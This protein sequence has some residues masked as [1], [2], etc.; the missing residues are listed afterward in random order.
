MLPKL[1][2]PNLSDR[3][4]SASFD[5]DNADPAIAWDTFK[6]FSQEPVDGVSEGFLWEIGCFN[7][8]GES[9]FIINLVRQFTFSDGDEYDHLEQLSLKLFCA[10]TPQLQALK[11]AEWSF[12]HVSPQHFFQFVESL[13]EFS[14]AKSGADW[15]AEL[16]QESV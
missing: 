6:R 11:R 9:Q 10:P 15:Y 7:F 2:A 14:I 5:F 3:L 1:A 13:P 8:T 16:T 12:N 4:D